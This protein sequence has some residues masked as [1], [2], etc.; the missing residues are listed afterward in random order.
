LTFQEAQYRLLADL[1]ERIHNGDLT[2]RGLARLAG[3]SQPHIH[4]VLKG[5]RFLSYR[6]MD[7]LLKSVNVSLLDLFSRQELAIHLSTRMLPQHVFEIP[8]LRSPLGP[9]MPWPETLEFHKK[10][11]IPS[12]LKYS[13]RDLVLARL[14]PD[15]TMARILSD[16]D[17]AALD[18][19]SHARLNVTPTGVYAIA[20][21]SE[22]ILRH[23][24]FGERCIYLATG[25]NI[26]EPETWE[27]VEIPGQGILALLKAHVVW[28]GHAS[29]KLLPPHQRGRFLDDATS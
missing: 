1:Q 27:A 25:E 5:A 18:T 16:F 12:N 10:L 3:I 24:R 14:M 19:S 2:E 23:V 22:A 8:C 21:G 29:D 9:N 11:V 6:S 4:N 13:A 28:A 7:T 26:D 15:R 20:R 17:I